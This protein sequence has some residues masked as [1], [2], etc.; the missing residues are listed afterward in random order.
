MFKCRQAVVCRGARFD[1]FLTR[2]HVLLP[3]YMFESPLQSL[4]HSH[5]YPLFLLDLFPQIAI[6]VS[7]EGKKVQRIAQR[8]ALKS[9]SHGVAFLYSIFY[10]R[11][12]KFVVGRSW[13]YPLC[14]VAVAFHMKWASATKGVVSSADQS[15]C[16]VLNK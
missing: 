7:E 4:K 9:L 6:R 8:I 11:N 3:R 16:P 5:Q 1:L 12:R 10:T 13:L 15:Y 2:H 14:M